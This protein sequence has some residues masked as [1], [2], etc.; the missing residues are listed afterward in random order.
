MNE[1]TA[2]LFALEKAAGFPFRHIHATGSYGWAWMPEHI[3]SLGVEVENCESIDLR[4]YIYDMPT[5]MAA[6]DIFIS[7]AGASSCNEIAVSGTPCILIPSPNVTDNH[8][9]KNA[10]IVEGRGGCVLLV[11]KECSAQ[12]LYQE[13]EALLSDGERRRVMRKALIESS[14]PD[15]AE[16]IC[17]IIRELAKK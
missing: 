6:A 4:E 15:S 16:R 13:V 2:K 5:L 8:Q 7:R 10:R 3:R 9:E 11:E 17:A 1:M 14:M 12:R